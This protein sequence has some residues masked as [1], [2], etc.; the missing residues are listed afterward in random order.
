MA[1]HANLIAGKPAPEF[2]P[3]RSSCRPTLGRR[4][5]KNGLRVLKHK[6]YVAGELSLPPEWAGARVGDSVA[7]GLPN[8]KVMRGYVA[9][10]APA[11]QVVLISDADHDAVMAI[12]ARAL[13][14]QAE[15]PE[16]QLYRD[17][18]LVDQAATDK[19]LRRPPELTRA[20]P[21]SDAYN[22]VRRLPPTAPSCA[23]SPPAPAT[24]PPSEADRAI[25]IR[26]ARQN[27]LKNLVP[28]HPPPRAG[29]GDRACPARAS[30]SL[31]FDTL[32]AEGQRRY[33]E[34]FSPYARQFLDRMDKPAGG[35]RSRA[36][37]RPSPST[38][39][40]R[41]APPARTVG[42]MTELADHF[43]LLY[44][45]AAR[46]H[47]R[48]CGKPVQRDTPATHP[49]RPA[50]PRRGGGRPAPGGELPGHACRPTSARTR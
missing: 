12:T 11:G 6:Q 33:V 47:C 30:R 40:T 38:R 35:S 10:V 4:A 20:Q 39:P 19:L 29:G 13:A 27:N 34:T 24:T 25:R 16:T 18:S 3:R 7:V 1:L 48:G 23:P 14:Q 31:V 43:K 2:V 22:R 44:A 5:E 15:S 50:G 41:C 45:R 26:G 28:R 46:L 36:C 37:R 42:T 9:H 8:D 32:Y 17:V 49:R 21:A